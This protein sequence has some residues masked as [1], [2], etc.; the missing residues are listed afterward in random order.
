MASEHP[1]ISVIERFDP[2]DI[3]KAAEVLAND[4]VFHFF[5]P[6][7]LD[8]QGDYIGVEEIQSFFQTMRQ[9]TN[10]TF[11]VNPISQTTVGKELVV[12]QT[13]NTM[14]LGGEEIET[15]VVLVFRIVEGQIRE[16]WDIPSVYS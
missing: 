1:N 5:N 9:F 14:I 10:G 16:I 11:K 12:V 2:T 4:V 7:L 3:S 8:L 13:R 6:R 15:D